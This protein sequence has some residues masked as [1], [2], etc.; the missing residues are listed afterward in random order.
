MSKP[1]AARVATDITSCSQQRGRAWIARTAAIAFAGGAPVVFIVLVLALALGA[2]AVAAEPTP[3]PPPAASPPATAAPSAAMPAAPSVT[4]PSPD[5]TGLEA[6]VASQLGEARQA[7]VTALADAS[8]QPAARATAWGELGQLYHAYGLLDAAVVCYREAARLAPGELRWP[9]LL[10]QAERGRSDLAAA[11]VAFTEALV[12][13]RY[14]PAEVALAEIALAEGDAAAAEVAA[15]RALQVVPGDAAAL[16]ALGQAKLSQRDFGAAR[17]ALQAALAAVPGANRLHYPLALAYRGLGDAERAN[18]ELALVGKTGVRTADPL[19]DEIDSA[20]RGELAPLL[21]GRRAAAAG[22]WKAA[23]ED[24][25]RALAA[26][27]ESVTARVDLSAALGSTGDPAGARRLLE[28]ALVREPSNATAHF[29]LGV[30]LLQAGDAAG[31]LPHL[32]AAAAARPGDA[33]AVRTLGDVLLALGRPADALPRFRAA[34]AA[35]PFDEAARF[36]EAATLVRSGQLAEARE[37]LE[38][39]QKVMPEQGRLTHLYARLLA[40][41]PDLSLRNGERAVELARKVW[42]AQP[43]ADHGRTLA[44][45]LAEAGRCA[46]AAKLAR[47]LAEQ[48]QGAERTDLETVAKQWDAGPPCRPVAGGPGGTP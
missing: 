16:A 33:E 26:N 18:Q 6:A 23:A 15:R 25:R 4:P 14:P 13:G 20:R 41:A 24:F 37:R 2:P 1:P 31:A 21:R 10:G 19:L 9:Y 28:E 7:L 45:A 3:T 39:A 12:R 11:R 47:A 40:V 8:S 35:A 46:D 30:L 29:N 27:P 38:E 42:D 5:L 48:L 34:I 32:E 17:D 22:D 44:L 36:G 43:T